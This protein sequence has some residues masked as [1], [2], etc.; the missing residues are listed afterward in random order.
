M[1]T[2]TGPSVPAPPPSPVP[3]P[4]PAG[5]SAPGPAD[6]AQAA[7]T[8]PTG[9]AWGAAGTGWRRWVTGERVGL[10]VLLVGTAVLYLWGLGRSGWANAY[11]SAAAQAG[12]QSWVAWFF[13]SS[14][15]GNSITVD[16]TPASLWVMGLS[17][18]VFGLNAWSILGPQALAGVASVGLL[19]SA[20]RRWFGPGAGLLSGA[21]LALTPVAVLMFRFNNPDALLVLLLVAAAY[22]VVRAL[23][24]ASTRWLVLAGA[25]VGFAFLTKM[26]QALLVLPAFG[27]V[28][29]VAAPTSLRRRLWQLVLATLGMVVAAGW[30]VAVVELVPA[31]LRP[32]VGGSQTDS[33]LELTLGYNGLGRLTGEEVGSVGGGNGWGETGWLRL[34]G[35][36]LGGQVAWLLPAALV[37]LVTGLLLTARAARTDRTRAALLL[38][39]G[40]LV[41]TAL[42]FS[43]MRGIFHAYYAVALAP[44]VGAVVG[45]GATV[46]WRRRTTL[47]ASVVMAGTLA[48]TAV[49]SA[50]LLSRSPDW[51]PSLRT[52]VLVVGLGAA[53][54]L[55]FAG[56]LPRRA[57][58]LIGATA[59]VAALAAPAAYAVDTAATPHAGAIPSAGPAVTGGGPGGPGGRG[60]PGGPGGPGGAGFAGGPGAG[61]PGG[62]APPGAMAGAP[63]GTRPGQVLGG[64][65]GGRAGGGPG[66]LLGAT[67]PGDALVALLSTDADRYTWVAAAVGANNAAG[68]QLATDLPVM[69]IGGFNGS[70]PSPTLAQFQ[71]WVAQGRVHYFVGGGGPGGRGNGGGTASQQIAQ[72]VAAEFTAT[73]VDGVTVYDLTS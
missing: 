46:L 21:V 63:P 56:R 70:D 61:G 7:V 68:Y 10:A 5:R 35:A 6:S 49:W 9:G 1:T 16:K 67:T 8:V 40:W 65:G 69:P 36:D 37:L 31:R 47:W 29:L 26:L 53:A 20:V 32:Y 14:D 57:G 55:L 24:H 60:G 28:Y 73:T 22:A 19:Y 15:A 23:E 27:L 4:G 12:S 54:A 34:L 11:Y 58:T 25:L 50:D 38:W 3:A 44:A 39:G 43:F 30:W 17:V 18:R 64:T 51:Y 13:G 42:V 2:L 66:G 48:F 59:V 41:V 45:I 33:V 62:F 72:W 71:E 52:A